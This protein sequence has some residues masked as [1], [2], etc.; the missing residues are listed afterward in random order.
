MTAAGAASAAEGVGIGA[1]TLEYAIRA[2]LT[3]GVLI[4]GLACPHL[5]GGAE[6]RLAPLNN[7]RSRPRGPEGRAVQAARVAGRLLPLHDN[8]S[9]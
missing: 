7:N 6:D 5:G 4:E 3:S 1:E 2:L 8:L 9:V